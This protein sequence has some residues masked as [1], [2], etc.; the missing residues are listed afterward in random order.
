MRYVELNPVR[1]GL[2]ED[3]TQWRWS[4]ARAHTLGEPD[5]YIRPASFVSVGRDWNELL[6]K[7]CAKE[8]M[9]ELRERTRTGRPCGS[10]T[11]VSKVESLL[12]RTLHRRKPGRKRQ[13]R[14]RKE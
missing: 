1:A 8:E 10:K 14:E 11:F 6:R 12:G 9:L 13:K 7:G 3:P 4:S 5:E 2:V